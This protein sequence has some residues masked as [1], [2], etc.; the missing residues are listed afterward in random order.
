MLASFRNMEDRF[1]GSLLGLAIGDAIGMPVADLPIEETKS[2]FGAIRGYE[3]RDAGGDNEIPAGEITDETETV[4]CI[5]ESMTVNNG[6]VD[7]ENINARLMHLVEGPSRHWMP[8]AMQLGIRKAFESDGLVPES[9]AT[10]GSLAVAVRGVPVGLMHSIGGF[11]PDSLVE[12]ARRVSRLS[13]GGV[14]QQQL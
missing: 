2:R 8:E 6:L 13:H 11:S 12:D 9:E 3:A 7:S 14:G 10:D 5:V 1:L 4:L